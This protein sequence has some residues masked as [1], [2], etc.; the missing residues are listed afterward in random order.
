MMK[1]RYRL[2]IYRHFL[3]YRW[4]I[5]TFFENINIDKIL[6][7]KFVHIVMVIFQILLSI[8][9]DINIFKRSVNISLKFQ[10]M[11]IYRQSISIFHHKSMKNST[12]LLKKW[13]FLPKMSLW[14][15]QGDHNFFSEVININYSIEQKNNNQCQSH[16]LLLL[17]MIFRWWL[18]D[19]K[20]CWHFC[21]WYFWAPY[22]F[23][24][25]A[26]SVQKR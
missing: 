12:C 18:L 8:F 19:G 26:G 16:I 17:L 6:I 22:L 25:L 7:R 11:L 3:K 20:N 5:D 24:K 14:V 4:N 10:K 23:T 2:S 9:F 13:I 1:Y 21:S 15:S